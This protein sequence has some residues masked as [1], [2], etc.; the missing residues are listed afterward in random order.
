MPKVNE[1]V[2]IESW[3]LK[4]TVS[5][6]GVLAANKESV[7]PDGGSLHVHP[8]PFINTSLRRI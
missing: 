5:F 7:N 1:S 6:L 3:L 8:T 2:N 4:P